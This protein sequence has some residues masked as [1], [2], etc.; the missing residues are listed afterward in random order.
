MNWTCIGAACHCR[1]C[2]L[3]LFFLYFWGFFLYFWGFF[4]SHKDTCKIVNE[5]SVRIIVFFTEFVL[6]PHTDLRSAEAA[7]DFL[8]MNAVCH[9]CSCNICCFS[10]FFCFPPPFPPTQTCGPQR[11]RMIVF[12]ACSLL[13]SPLRYAFRSGSKWIP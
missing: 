2:V 9:L 5:F 10:R 13:F 1:I 4:L 8:E 6:F 12:F 3:L 11:Q 7:N